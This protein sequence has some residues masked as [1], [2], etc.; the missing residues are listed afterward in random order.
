MQ[1]AHGELTHDI[2]GA[3]MT[4]HRS[5]GPGFIESIYS[6][7]I[8]IELRRR[9]LVHQREHKIS[10]R[11]GDIDVGYHRLDL[12]VERAIVVE[13]K[14]VKRLEDVH[15]VVVRSYL[16]AAGLEHGLLMNFAAATLEVRRVLASRPSVPGFLASSAILPTE[17]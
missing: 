11:Y 14:A 5:L 4:V 16:R 7:A 12:L 15:F 1:L 8:A 10:V 13:L 17:E 2:I 9:G 3:A 6:N